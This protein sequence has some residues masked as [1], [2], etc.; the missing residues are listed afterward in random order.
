MAAT[1]GFEAEAWALFGIL[2]CW[3]IP[4]F[5]AIA[6]LHDADYARGGYRMLPG[7]DPNLRATA[8][9]TLLWFAALLPTSLMPTRMGIAGV[10]YFYAALVLGIGF[11][12]A[13]VFFAVKRTRS[14]ARVLFGA[15]IAY[16]AL[17]WA[18]LTL[19]PA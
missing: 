14:S 11:G 7:E 17:L 19:L 4:H 1:G 15:S 2:F 3:Q 5:L 9:Q 6:T 8:R 18:A 16:L 10:P 13:C 12:A